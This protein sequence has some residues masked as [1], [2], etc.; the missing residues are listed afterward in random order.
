MLKCNDLQRH[1]VKWQGVE[2]TESV[3]LNITGSS[4]KTLLRVI[5]SQEQD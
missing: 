3:E 1:I 4:D 2:G 5:P